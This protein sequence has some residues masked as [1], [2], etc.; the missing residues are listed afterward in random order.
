MNDASVEAKL[1]IDLESNLLTKGEAILKDVQGEGGVFHLFFRQAF[2]GYD[3]PI[4]IEKPELMVAP[5]GMDLE[6]GA[7]MQTYLVP[8]QSKLFDTES[9]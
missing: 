5:P 6:E 8:S 7:T 9:N 2:A 3:A 4:V 1:W